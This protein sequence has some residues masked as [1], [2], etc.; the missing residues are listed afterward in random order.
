MLGSLDPNGR[1]LDS[2]RGGISSLLKICV[3]SPSNQPGI[4]VEFM[5]VQV[6]VKSADVDYLGNCGNLS[7]VIGPFAVDSGVFRPVEKDG[8]GQ[9]VTVRVFNTNMGKVI[10][11]T[12]PVCGD[13]AVVSGD[14]VIDGVAGCVAQVKLDFVDPAGAKTGKMLPTGSVMDC[15]DGI[16]ATC[17]DVGNPSVFVVVEELRVNEVMLPDEMQKM[18]GLLKRL[19]WIRQKAVMKM[20]MADTLEKVP[21]LIPKICFVSWPCSHTLLSGEELDGSSVDVVVRAISVGQP[22]QV[23][24]IMTSLSLA[25]AAKIPGSVVNQY[26]RH[27]AGEKEDL[28]IGHL[29]GKI[30]V[31]AKVSA[32]GE[33]KRATVYRTARRLMDGVVYWK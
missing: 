27:G 12:F 17:V 10:E 4:N 15:I 2:L 3:V 6:G 9:N 26:V 25:V 28:V 31:G 23:L 20:G 14:F 8:G 24:L 22:H 21:A 32:G 33:V 19:E 11:S 18:S 30:L 5:F 29:S 16:Q 7:S 13:E 1:Q